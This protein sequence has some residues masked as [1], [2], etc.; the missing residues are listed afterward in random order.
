MF[1]TIWIQIYMLHECVYYG[2]VG[3]KMVVLWFGDVE[4]SNL[5]HNLN[6]SLQ[7]E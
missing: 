4:T 7:Y 3:G 5:F 2:F 6:L 1:D